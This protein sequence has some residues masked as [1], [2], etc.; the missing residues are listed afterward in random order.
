MKKI[1]QTYGLSSYIGRTSTGLPQPVF[2][3]PHY[4]ILED[5]PPVGLITGSPGSGKTF[6]AMTIAAQAS[7]MGKT[8]FILDPKGDFLALKKL[9]RA[10]EINKTNV[11]S[12]FINEDNHD[13]SEDNYG[14]LDPLSLTGNRDDNVSLTVDVINS[15]VS[16]VSTTQSNYLLP[17]IRDVAESRDPSLS[18][19]IRQLQS[20]QN[21]EVR[22]LGIALDVPLKKSIAKLLVGRG[23]AA[24]YVNPF[25][26]ADG[27]TIISLMGLSLPNADESES[28]YSSDERLSTV[29]MRL[30][31]QLI[32]E[33]MRNQPKRIQ[34]LLIVD[35]AWVVFGNKSGKK[36][37]N[38]AALLGR[39]LN[40]A[41][42]LA[43]QSPRHIMSAGDESSTLDT[44]I[45]T[46]FAF[47]N[48]SAQDNSLTREAMKLPENE[49][50][51]TVFPA[52]TTGQC[53]MRD[54]QGRHA[55]IQIVTTKEW[56]NAFNTNPSA[57]LNKSK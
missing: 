42:I 11:W 28:D 43:T 47:R 16:H 10:G 2:F 34:K 32:L 35:E 39:S 30:L 56:E 40:M 52:F 24:N 38:N 12:I 57:S 25:I 44:T 51:E 19:V 20:N 17:I 23:H 7:V 41:I 31:T 15:L 6:L 3:D 36:L 55:I 46:R 5:R 54:C 4:P 33:A 53:M 49:H 9:E 14:L 21:D 50:W 27:C 22:N 37:I 45:S 29:V 18:R 26:D 1:M 48:D 8:S 13:V